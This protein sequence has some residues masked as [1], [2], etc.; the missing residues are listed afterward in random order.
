M[1]TFTERQRFLVDLSYVFD[2]AAAF[3]QF[4]ATGADKCLS[5]HPVM[6][7]TVHNALLESSLAFLRK[8]NEFFGGNRDISIS[9]YLPA[10]TKR[11]LF[12][13]K[14]STLLNDRVMHLSLDEAKYGKI[15]WTAFFQRNLPKAECRFQ[16]FVA[17]LR[18]ENPEYFGAGGSSQ[19]TPV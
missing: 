13:K 2:Q 11:W 18:K 16:T 10:E 5:G 1:S 14:D 9:D 15:D 7:Q 12:S 4:Y 3:R 6:L 17:Q 8:I 19:A